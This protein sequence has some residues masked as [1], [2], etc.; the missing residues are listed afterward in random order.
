MFKKMILKRLKTI[1]NS[2]LNKLLIST[3]ILLSFGNLVTACN[4]EKK[5][6]AKNVEVKNAPIPVLTV[7]AI[8]PSIKNIEKTLSVTGNLSAWD[9]VYA[10]ASA[11][12]LKVINIFAEAGQNVTKGQ[13]LVQLD[14]SML[15][16][17][18]SSAKA[19]LINAQAQLQKI[20]NPNR[21][22]D[23]LRQRASLQQAK[24][25]LDN[26]RE[27]AKRYQS[28]YEQGAV[29][30]FDLDS[31]NTSLETAQA[32]YNQEEQ[33]LNLLFAGSRTEDISIAQASVLDVQA[34]I[35]QIE[36]QLSQTVV[37]A[38]DS[39][40]IQ[41]RQV[42][43][44]DISSSVAK[45]FSIVRNNRFELQAK[46]P[47]SDLKNI[48]VGASV[49]ISSDVDSKI[50]TFG[51]I[52]QIGPGVDAVTRQAIVKID[53][54]Y[55]AG[56]QTGQ[57]LRGIVNLGKNTSLVIPSKSILNQE[58]ITKVYSVD[59]KSYANLK[60]VEVGIRDGEYVEV[61]SGLTKNDKI[62]I[63]GIGFLRDGDFVKVLSS[64]K[65]G[66]A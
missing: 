47:E 23:I 33:R 45:M 38:P 62:I 15:K 10:Q 64:S 44:G 39:G 59:E 53:V 4:S 16:A 65:G 13:V 14:D 48:K 19:R 18:L 31:R 41:E 21:E 54:D 34:Q 17:Q 37:K 6:E 30:R 60:T 3:I 22:Q 40:L 5:V 25:N 2:N 9:M 58:G 24:A 35:Q 28:L 1:K 55:V 36:V 43:L 49:K 29:S 27:N 63:D 61:K 66:K 11:N 26:A 8:N 51:N 50:K 42:H 12:G 32:F 52:R 46:V 56:M 57:F 7:T 20:K